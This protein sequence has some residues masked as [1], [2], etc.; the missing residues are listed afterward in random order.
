M[1]KA[2]IHVT[3]QAGQYLAEMA[4]RENCRELRLGVQYPGTPIS[5][6]YLSFSQERSSDDEVVEFE[7]FRLR[8]K[9]A[10]AGFIEGLS[11]EYRQNRMGSEVRLKAPNLHNL[12]QPPEDADLELR[13]NWVLNQ[14]VNPSLAEHQGSVIVD[15][16]E[17]EKVWLKFGGNCLGC[18]NAEKTLVEFVEKTLLEHLPEIEAISEVTMH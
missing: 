9:R 2:N 14:H 16:V 8:Y 1:S 7:G 5:Q 3:E 4:A 17:G 6:C 12:Q 18:G 13:A 15:R 10:L 11:V